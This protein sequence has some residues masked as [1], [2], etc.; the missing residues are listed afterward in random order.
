MAEYM[1]LMRNEGVPMKEMS[2]EERAKS[3]GEWGEWMG[4]LKAQGKLKGGLPFNPGVAA[5][6]NS[7][8]EATN[9]FHTHGN[10]VNVGGLIFSENSG[11]LSSN[12]C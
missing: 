8:K 10:N 5:V 7:K 11:H 6:V 2:D 9:T 3:M 12:I 4:G 1:L